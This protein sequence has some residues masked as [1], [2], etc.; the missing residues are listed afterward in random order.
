MWRRMRRS[1][2]RPSWR[3][4]LRCQPNPGAELRRDCRP[5][6]VCPHRAVRRGVPADVRGEPAGDAAQLTV[7]HAK[8]ACRSPR[9]RFP[10]PGV[11]KPRSFGGTELAVGE[12][13]VKRPTRPRLRSGVRYG[14]AP[15]Q[16]LDVRR[17]RALRSPPPRCWCS[18]PEGV[19]ARRAPAAGPRGGRGHRPL[20]A[21][22]LDGPLDPRTARSSSDSSKTS[23]SA[24]PCTAIVTSSPTPQRSP[25]CTPT[26]H[27][28][29]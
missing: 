17:R 21:L 9:R 14:H 3:C 28:L 16:V 24:R 19:A 4:R 7:N 12:G 27:R 1:R 2:W 11:R 26:H 29:W 5:L 15:P 10:P 20:R 6:G 8:P 22:R 18:C 13:P 25:V 23:W